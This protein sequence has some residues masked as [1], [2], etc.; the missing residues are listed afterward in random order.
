M[1]TSDGI[2]RSAT[3][4][5]KV[6]YPIS[7][8]LADI[9]PFFY[10]RA[11]IYADIGANDGGTFEA[12]LDMGFSVNRAILIE[13]N[14][15]IFA[16]LQDAV[17]ARNQK[18]KFTC[19]NLAMSDHEGIVHLRD[20]EDMSRI[21]AEALPANDAGDADALA[22]QTFRVEARPFDTLAEM[23]PDGHVSLLK[24]DVEGHEAQVLRGCN[25][26]LTAR[27]VD[28]LYIE[29]GVRSDNPQ[30]TYFREI[31]DL[32]SAQGYHLFRIYEQ[33]QEWIEDSPALRRFYVAYFS[34]T[35]VAQ[36]A[37]TMTREL[38]RLDKELN[39][40][41]AS[42]A[43]LTAERDAALG[44]IEH[45]AAALQDRF[46]EIA[47]LTKSLEAVVEERDAAR[48]TE[49]TKAAA[50]QDRFREI[51]LLTKSLEAVVEERDA[52]LVKLKMQ[53]KDKKDRPDAAAFPGWAA[54]GLGAH[55]RAASR[56]RGVSKLGFLIGGAVFYVVAIVAGLAYLFFW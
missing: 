7:A 42:I 36:F 15:K 24:I 13:A 3:A 49:R 54:L 31:D 35:F 4:P 55:K 51:A 56:K 30:Q 26:M 52:A 37:M 38:A 28:V 18:S 48:A 22:N 21:V 27:A 39:A 11:M 41:K 2:S 12:V 25:A 23:F 14:S 9:E 50:L 33:T 44:K 43:S 32:L 53:G 6:K 34:P 40:S 46:R 17:A 8:F 5:V 19:L 20:V 16:R 45:E 29:A 1:N 10:K 47:L